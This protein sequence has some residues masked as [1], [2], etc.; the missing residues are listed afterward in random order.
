MVAVG[1]VR[2]AEPTAA[3]PFAEDQCAAFWASGN[4]LTWERFDS[5]PG[6]TGEV[7]AVTHFDDVVI[8]VGSNAKAHAEGSLATVWI[9]HPVVPAP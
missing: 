3:D 7:S 5:V 8:A 2:C 1:S 4:G 6:P 9:G